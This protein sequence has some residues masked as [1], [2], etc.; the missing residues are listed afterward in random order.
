[1]KV[2]EL[3]TNAAGGFGK[4]YVRGIKN[5]KQALA[6]SKKVFGEKYYS[7]RLISH[8][9]DYPSKYGTNWKVTSYTIK[10]FIERVKPQFKN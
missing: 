1:M 2:Y 8:Y 9:D 7:P 4:Y 10:S 5:D 3:T 6:L